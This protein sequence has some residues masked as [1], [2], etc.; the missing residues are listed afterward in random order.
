MTWSIQRAY[1]RWQVDQMLPGVLCL[2]LTYRCSP[3]LCPRYIESYFVM[4]IASKS[5][6]TCEGVMFWC[7]AF[8]QFVLEASR[9][10][11]WDQRPA[12]LPGGGAEGLSGLDHNSEASLACPVPTCW[13]DI[14]WLRFLTIKIV[15][16]AWVDGIVCKVTRPFLWFSAPAGTRSKRT[17]SLRWVELSFYIPGIQS[18][19]SD[20][21][22]ATSWWNSSIYRTTG[23]FMFLPCPRL[24][25][26]FADA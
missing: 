17:A 14:V 21:R 20:T 3:R 2:S 8:V 4:S 1:L 23:F 7:P 11:V 12:K 16:I 13:Q 19:M 10:I 22:V 15:K 18:S 26:G 9:N 25:R 5:T 24:I 6:L